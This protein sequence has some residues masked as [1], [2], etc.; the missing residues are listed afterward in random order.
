MNQE[1]TRCSVCGAVVRQETIIY[2]QI[3]DDKVYIVTGVPAE[4]CSQC[5]EQYLSPD[6][7]DA[8]QSVI[9]GRE[10]PETRQVPV[11]HFP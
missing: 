1:A 7:A 3:L 5:G 10:A 6:T 2:T 4:V 8:L 11:F 9:E